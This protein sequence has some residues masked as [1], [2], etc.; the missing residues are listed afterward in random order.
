MVHHHSYVI[1]G[2][3]SYEYCGEEDK[4]NDRLSDNTCETCNTYNMLKLTRHLFCW[5]PGQDLADYYER[6]LYNHILASQNPTTGMMCY[7]VPLRMGTQKQFSDRFN[8]F[9]CCVGTGMENH[10]KYVESIYYQAK[11][12][13]LYLNLFIPSV[14]NWKEK[15]VVIRQETSFPESNKTT[16]LLTT[17]VSKQFPLYIRN[18]KWA[19]DGVRITVNGKKITTLKDENGFLVVDRKWNNNDK[20]E[21]L[22]PMT[23]HSEPMPDNPNRVAFLYGPVVLAGQLGSETP[24]P[25]V[26]TPVLLTDDH[27]VS[28]WLKTGCQSPDDI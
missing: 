8:T 9:T 3:S 6:A 5:Q 27:T 11:D 16:L 14:L 22:L 13:G 10:S 7:F 24:D 28:D 15:G 25:L 26:G 21:I 23:V 20:V 18:P 1:G 17:K 19:N 2:N 4:L 12:G